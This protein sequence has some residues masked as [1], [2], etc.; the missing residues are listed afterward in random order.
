MTGKLYNMAFWLCPVALVNEKHIT[1][2]VPS[3]KLMSLLFN[4]V[5]NYNGVQTKAQNGLD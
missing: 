2:D 4:V 1:Y 5:L 3:K